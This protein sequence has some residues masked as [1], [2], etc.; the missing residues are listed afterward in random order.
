RIERL[1]HP[2]PRPVA[3]P[4]RPL[5]A[6]PPLAALLPPPLTAGRLVGRAFVVLTGELPGLRLFRRQR[7][8]DVLELFLLRVHAQEDLRDAADRHHA[9]TDQERDHH[10]RAAVRR[11]Q[12]PE[13]QRPD[14][15]AEPGT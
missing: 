8:R 6:R 3:T 1:P 14:D 13:E 15:P 9:R 4:A 2:R 7:L 12:M 11:D 5:L 10:P